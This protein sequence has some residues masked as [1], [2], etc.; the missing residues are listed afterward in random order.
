M[1]QQSKKADEI[2][3]KL[4]KTTKAISNGIEV[5][6]PAVLV[7]D[8]TRNA[9]DREVNKAVSNSVNW[10]K[11]TVN[12]RINSEVKTA[13]EAAYPDVKEGIRASL[14]KQLENVDITAL[15]K[16]VAERAA[17]KASEKFNSEFQSILDDYNSRLKHISDIYSSISDAITK[18]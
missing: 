9:V 5:D 7:A 17:E 11:D 2:T 8:A 14:T 13:V 3:D 18:K 16:E 15:R 6:V 1:Y 4:E 10:L 12:N